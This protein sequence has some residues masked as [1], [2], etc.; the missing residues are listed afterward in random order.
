VREPL[1]AIA[2]KEYDTRAFA[3]HLDELA[4][5]GHGNVLQKR[6]ET[7]AARYR[8][9]NPLLQP[10]VLMRG[11]AEGAVAPDLLRGSA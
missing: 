8:F 7:G 11:L 9:V 4:G 5:P 6:S 2:G 1:G 10:Y 3:R